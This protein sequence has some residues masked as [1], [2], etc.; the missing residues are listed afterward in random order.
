MTLWFALHTVGT[1]FS[2]GRSGCPCFTV[3]YLYVACLFVC[4]SIC[5]II[6]VFEHG[7][8]VRR[9]C[10]ENQNKKRRVSVMNQS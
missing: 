5:M 10:V 3:V 9:E 6:R 7:Y 2:V 4:L 1:E 8:V